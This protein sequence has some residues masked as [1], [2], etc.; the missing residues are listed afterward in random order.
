M[1]SIYLFPVLFLLLP[2]LALG[3]GHDL[4]EAFEDEVVELYD[5]FY[6]VSREMVY[7]HFNKSSYL[8]GDGVWFTSYVLNPQ[9]LRTSLQANNLWV[10]F[11]GSSGKLVERHVLPVRGGVASGVLK[12]GQDAPPGTYTYRAYT[13]W[14]RNFEETPEEQRLIQVLGASRDEAVESVSDLD[15][16]FLPESGTL[17]A[18]LTNRVGI[19]AV[20]ADGR[21]VPV[22]GR[23]V[24]AAGVPVQTFELNR[25]GMGSIS[26]SAEVGDVLYCEVPM[27]DG[28]VS[29]FPLPEVQA[30]GVVVQVSQLRE[31]VYV[32]VA[33]NEQTLDEPQDFFLLIHHQGEVDRVAQV[34]LNEDTP[35]HLLELDAGDL[36]GGAHC[37]TLFDAAFQPVAERLF[38]TH[39]EGRR[40]EVALEAV[41]Q[42]DTVTLRVYTSKW[43]QP[44]EAHLSI[45]VLPGGTVSSSFVSSLLAEAQ[46]AGL[47]GHIENPH[48]Y[49]DENNEQ[50]MQ[51]MDALMLTQ[52]WRRYAWNRI[53]EG[54]PLALEHAHEEG[55]TVVGRV[56]QWSERLTGKAM[57][58]YALL[59]TGEVGF[60]SPDPTGRFEIRSLEFYDS[61]YV[62]LSVA[63][64]KGRAWD[65]RI[66]AEQYLPALDSAI[67]KAPSVRR[68]GTLSIPPAPDM[69]LYPADIHI[70]EVWFVGR[71]ADPPRAS[72]LYQAFEAKTFT[73]TQENSERYRSVTDLLRQEFSVINEGPEFAPIYKMN[74]GI[75]TINS[76]GSPL[77]IIDDVPLW[78]P[79]DDEI[80]KPGVYIAL[81]D[82][83]SSSAAV[84]ASMPISD[85][86]S[87]TVNKTGFGMGM[88]GVEGVIMVKTRTK[89]LHAK[90][91]AA[92]PTRVKLRGYADPVEF[93]TPRYSV[94]PPDPV[95]T[96]YA[97]VHWEPNLITNVNGEAT[98]RFPIPRRL[99]DIHVRVEGIGSDGTI[100]CETRVMNIN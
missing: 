14:M 68:S 45:S 30:R 87:I 49:F 67:V 42:R 43:A 93:Y 34:R 99:K 58:S 83:L 90:S 89:P 25:V 39:R 63:D 44:V 37:I 80:T 26:L 1:K 2:S 65:R 56:E 79:V 73:I 23:V 62:Y 19:K 52:G 17:L 59:G 24:T 96:K 94:L 47:H 75:N 71:R 11:Y 97:T 15:M 36:R 9:T 18:G 32:N 46:L 74:R 5:D 61:T 51:D 77:I 41:A 64:E 100:Y 66:V 28:D 10:E 70:D 95:Y 69:S 38:Y 50:R 48:H 57:V 3:Q 82:R 88:R 55:F 81:K 86:E 13:R 53:L 20:G 21:G 78:S 4:L 31:R 16:Q 85:I 40:G 76:H 7:T 29:R 27:A 12:L 22:T 8:P 72:D 60:V 33:S 98:V 84:L 92:T 6:S 35:S 91:N 54:D